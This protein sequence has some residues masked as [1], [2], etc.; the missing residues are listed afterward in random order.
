MIPTVLVHGGA[1]QIAPERVDGKISGVKVAANIG[2]EVILSG[3]SALDAVEAAIR[4]MEN[5]EYFNAGV[6]HCCIFSLIIIRKQKIISL[7]N[8]RDHN[9]NISYSN[10]FLFL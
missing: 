8:E 3:G 6:K 5:N 4:S 1:G 2:Y 10:I 9:L 7:K